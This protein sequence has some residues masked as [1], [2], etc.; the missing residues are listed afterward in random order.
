MFDADKLDA[1]EEY[2][3]TEFNVSEIADKHDFD[4]QAQT[5]RITDSD[6][7][8]LVTFARE[9]IEDNDASAISHSL[10]RYTLKNRFENEKIKRLVFA[11]PGL[12]ITAEH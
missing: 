6:R 4:R 9:F 3:K 5:F 10:Q 12:E 8:Y 1:I 2:L 7:I 11:G